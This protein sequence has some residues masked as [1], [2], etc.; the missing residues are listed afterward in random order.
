MSSDFNGNK[1]SVVI[2]TQELDVEVESNIEDSS[3]RS[4]PSFDREER[5]VNK[6]VSEDDF[7]DDCEIEEDKS[8]ILRKFTSESLKPNIG[9]VILALAFFCNSLM[10]VSTKV[11]VTNPERSS[12]ERIKPL[13]ILLVRMVLTYIGTL[14]YM[15]LN[16]ATI[17]NVPFGPPEVRKWL[18]LRGAC[19]FFGVFG[20]YFSLMYLCLSDALII[21]FLSP[22]VTIILAWVVLRENLTKYEVTSSLIS[23]LGVVL[24][25]RP[26]F[27]FGSR[28]MSSDGNDLSVVSSDPHERLIA[29]LVG[30]AGVFGASI[31]YIV[32][33]F[34]GNKA[35]AIMSVS[36]FSMVTAVISL[37]GIIIIPSMT[38]QIPSSLKEWLLFANLGVCGFFFQLLL[39]L[40]IQKEKAGRGT[41]MQYTQIIYAIFWDVLLWDVWPN[42]W[43]WG[44]MVL[45]IG[46]TLFMFILKKSVSKSEQALNDSE[47]RN[48]QLSRGTASHPDNDELELQNL[49]D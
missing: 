46:S 4:F 2:E 8:N 14:I 44:G 15:Y 45:I 24:I 33:R 11:L 26:E 3:N 1:S 6:S 48:L 20:M 36:Y 28:G 39:T 5:S 42:I 7:E 40:G 12:E 35:H 23:L 31:V 25:I 21:T 34:I 30:L 43:S 16:R 17:P 13:Q 49:S 32:I 10:I 29:S 18:L 37:I 9:L 38:F 19:G 22:S 27:I 41:L 47:G